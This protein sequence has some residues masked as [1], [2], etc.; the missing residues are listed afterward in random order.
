MTSFM[1]TI[2]D[3]V[4]GCTGCTNKRNNHKQ[5]EQGKHGVDNT[6]SRPTDVIDMSDEALE[7][8]EALINLIEAAISRRKEK[9]KGAGVDS[10]P[11]AS[12]ADMAQL[13]DP[14]DVDRALGVATTATPPSAPSSAGTTLAAALAA[15]VTVAGETAV[16]GGAAAAG[17]A[18]VT[19]G[20]VAAS[21]APPPPGAPASDPTEISRPGTTVVVPSEIPTA[22][23]AVDE[24]VEYEYEYY[25]DEAVDGR[26]DYEY[27][28]TYTYREGKSETPTS[29]ENAVVEGLSPDEYE[30]YY[31]D[32]PSEDASAGAS[33]RQGRAA[34]QQR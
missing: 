18:A 34:K 17:G 30:Y 6:L 1:Q 16:A 13:I 32:L 21:G 8:S 14:S 7:Q 15:E 12:G 27:S 26:G 3:S 5:L 10:Y 29:E 23:K 20:A 28:Y 2:G 31:E 19:G 22:A 24:Q 4:K 9:L 11:S 25:G 33:A